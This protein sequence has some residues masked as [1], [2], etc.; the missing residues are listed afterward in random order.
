MVVSLVASV[1]FDGAANAVTGVDALRFHLV[2]FVT[3]FAI[4]LQT[5]L[6]VFLPFRARFQRERTGT[7]SCSAERAMATVRAL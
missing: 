5:F 6:P 2:T 3:P 4:A 1:S 7:R